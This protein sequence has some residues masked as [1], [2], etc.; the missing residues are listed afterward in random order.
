[1]LNLKYTFIL[2]G[3]VTLTNCQ[4]S[5]TLAKKT[6][7]K[8]SVCNASYKGKVLPFEQPIEE[9]KNF[10]G[11]SPRFIQNNAGYE[12]TWDELGIYVIKFY[13]ES[14]P[15]GFFSPD[16]LYIFFENLE[17]P[18]AQAG[19]FQF[20]S[21]R[22]SLKFV[23]NELKDAKLDFPDE[24][25]EFIKNLNKNGK[26]APKNYLYPMHSVYKDTLLVDR[27]ALY[28]GI[29]LE[30]YNKQRALV[31]GAG[32]VGYW[33][34]DFDLINERGSTRVKTGEFA[35]SE[36]PSEEEYACAKKDNYYFLI[37]YRFTEKVLEYVKIQKVEKGKSF[38]WK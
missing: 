1:M 12:Y 23:E 18:V 34:R 6:D 9:W 35:D 37:T 33:D 13:D 26:R 7:F 11:Q 14:R 22:K 4:S 20:A 32:K 31:D 30:Q 27:V 38:Y 29:T 5:K 17:H 3:L 10:F 21:G 24:N 19:K 25:R 15:N 16:E 28:R 2:V 8:L 36:G